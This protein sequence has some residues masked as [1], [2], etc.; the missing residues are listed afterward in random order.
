MSVSGSSKEL[1]KVRVRK[2]EERLNKIEY[3]LTTF[4]KGV[5]N[6]S[7]EQKQNN[8][9]QVVTEQSTASDVQA[10]GSTVSG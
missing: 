7:I 9:V 1:L 10:E 4:L 8:N 6:G 2:L 5:A 3:I